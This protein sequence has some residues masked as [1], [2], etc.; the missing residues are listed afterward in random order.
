MGVSLKKAEK[1]LLTRAPRKREKTACGCSI[2]RGSHISMLAALLLRLFH[3]RLLDMFRRKFLGLGRCGWRGCGMLI[4]LKGLLV[5]SGGT[6]D[7][8]LQQMRISGVGG[9]PNGLIQ[10]SQGERRLFEVLKGLGPEPVQLR[11][12]GILL[13]GPGEAADG[14]QVVSAFTGR[15]ACVKSGPGSWRGLRGRTQSCHGLDRVSAPASRS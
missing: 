1:R 9:K 5:K 6:Q 12:G 3:C 15:Q 14:H 10:I 7:F 11:I 4:L 2:L 8:A 13:D